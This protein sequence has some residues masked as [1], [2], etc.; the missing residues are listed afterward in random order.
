MA[1]DGHGLRDPPT[2]SDENTG[3]MAAGDVL[4]R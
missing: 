2:G 4:D 3:A 1:L